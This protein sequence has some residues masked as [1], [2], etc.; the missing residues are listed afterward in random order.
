MYFIAE[1]KWDKVWGQ[2]MSDEQ[3]KINCA[4]KHFE[5]VNNEFA[6]IIKYAW[7]N[8]YK[9]K[10]MDNSFPEIFIDENYGNTV[11]LERMV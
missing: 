4:T 1:T 9:D 5:A 2:L 8:G 11:A 6:D 7:V 10:S 3:I